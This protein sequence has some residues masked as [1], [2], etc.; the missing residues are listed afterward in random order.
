M[1]TDISRVE[2]AL[3]GQTTIT[4]SGIVDQDVNAGQFKFDAQLAGVSVLK[5][6]GSLCADK[7]V[8]M[9]LNAGTIEFHGVS[10]PVTAGE[11]SVTLDI[12][13][14]DK[15]VFKHDLLTIDLSGLSDTGDKLL[16]AAR[17]VETTDLESRAEL[18]GLI[19][20]LSPEEMATQMALNEQ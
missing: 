1:I 7:E 4:D 5:D 13:L 16:C 12:N 10:W 19:V 15:S 2:L 14:L 18:Q 8:T 6:G 17:S 20:D 3:P 9:P 11:I